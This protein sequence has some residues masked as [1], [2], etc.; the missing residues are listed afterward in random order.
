MRRCSATSAWRSA[1]R[2]ASPT[3]RAAPAPAVDDREPIGPLF[4]AFWREHRGGSEAL[5]SGRSIGNVGKLTLGV[6]PRSDY[7]CH[8][9]L[10][11]LVELLHPDLFAAEAVA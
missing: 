3:R 4:D 6:L 5:P 1:S 8:A 2:R 7:A 10:C 9:V 11:A